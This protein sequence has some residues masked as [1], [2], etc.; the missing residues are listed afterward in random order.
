MP[1]QFKFRGEKA[2]RTLLNVTPPCTLQRVKNAIYEQA[3]IS[4][5]S[6]DLALEDPASG[7]ALDHRALL[8]Q[9]ALVQVIVRRTP[10]QNLAAPVVSL[11]V[12]SDDAVGDD[13]ED[14]AIDRM[15]EQ[16]DVAGLT[17]APSGALGRYSRSYRDAVKNQSRNREGYDL[18]GSDD[19]DQHKQEEP[20]PPGYT[21]HRCGM[22]GGKPESHWIWE[23]PTNDDPDHMRKVKTAKGVP[24]Q[25]LQKVESIEEGQKVSDGGVTFTLPGHSGHYVIAHQ[26]ASVEEQKRRVGDTVEEKVITAFSAGAK[27]AAESLKC[28]LCNQL[29][30][31]AVLA[32]CC[33]ASFCSDCVVD[34]LAHSSDL[35]HGR[36]PGCNEEVLAHQLVANEDI[37]KQVEQISRASKAATVAAQKISDSSNPTAFQVD[38]SIKD[39]VN[40]P[41]KYAEEAASDGQPLALTDGSVR[42]AAP[43]H[44][45][46]EG[47]QPL[48]FGPMLTEH[49]FAYWRQ[50]ARC[51]VPLQIKEQFADWQRKMREAKPAVLLALPAPDP[52]SKPVAAALVVS[53]PVAVPPAPASAPA[54]APA[55]APSPAAVTAVTPPGLPAPP[56]KEAFE[57]WQKQLREGKRKLPQPL[58]SAAT[59]SAALPSA[60]A[61]SATPVPQAVAPAVLA[62]T[63]TTVPTVVPLTAVAPTPA[64]MPQDPREPKLKKAKKEKKEKKKSKVAAGDL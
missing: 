42:P 11:A 41:K 1:V 51:G 10:V 24:R 64:A 6:T 61:S 20:P 19:D 57:E 49:Q 21:C 27:M 28:P 45:L 17:S 31:Q 12:T 37:R 54:V 55:V 63:A 40:R 60:S 26:N 48:G 4:E 18:D 62:A 53:A 44:G 32:P 50:G 29:F 14:E 2:F 9:E 59:S 16:H 52:V 56:S 58:P 34:R 46:G 13:Q 30:R 8:V 5:R 15:V 39:R 43:S 35:E 47:W 22:T 7:L 38:T 33:G 25:F 3:R 36:C 23:C